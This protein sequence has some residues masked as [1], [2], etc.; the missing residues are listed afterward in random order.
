MGRCPCG[1]NSCQMPFASEC[2]VS[3]RPPG[4][5]LWLSTVARPVLQPE[6]GPAEL[7]CLSP[8]CSFMWSAGRRA[9]LGWSPQG[10]SSVG[11]RGCH[12]T[13]Q[14]SHGLTGRTGWSFRLGPRLQLP[15]LGPFLIKQVAG[16]AQLSEGVRWSCGSLGATV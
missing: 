7:L 11:L 13:A 5:G 2:C 10:L 3:D 8:G 6:L 1:E 4:T 16:P 14:S 12:L 15:F 9:P